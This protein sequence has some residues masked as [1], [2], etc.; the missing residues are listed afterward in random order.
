MKKAIMYGAGNI[1]RGFI[2]QLFSLSG[3]ETVFIDINEAV[4][5]RLNADRSYP[6]YIAKDGS[7]TET[8]VGNVR[9]VNGK[10]ISA[11]AAEIA[12][13]D[14]MATAVG[15]NVLPFVAA[16][17]AA[18]V[19]LRAKTNPVPLNIIICENLLGADAY[20]RE[21][22]NAKL[23]PEAAGF[24]AEKV[25]LVEA[26]IG[27]MV[28]ATPAELAQKNPLIVC[29]EEYCT[30][31]VD[32]AAF[33]GEI[34]EIKNLYPFTPFELFIQRKLFM[35]NM[36][37][38]L[39]AYLGNLHG[40]TY[41]YEAIDLPAI[42]DCAAK[43]LDESAQALAAE[44]KVDLA[45]LREHAADLLHRYTNVLLGDTIARVGKDT[46]RKLAENDRL[47]GALNLCRKHGIKAE[48]IAVGIAAGLRFA[49]EGDAAAAEVSA[50]AREQGVAA[51][52]AKYSNLTD[53]E[54]VRLIEDLYRRLA[55][56][57]SFQL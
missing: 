30:L 31:P 15:V 48:H 9:A 52:L 12:S 16:P 27:R 56:I 33:V 41:I 13:A 23:E 44:H 7:Y 51:A 53:P 26:S 42:R 40:L 32:R 54:T 17:I 8:S 14:I 43:A 36:S 50:C 47:V 28:P 21:L 57:R 18:G 37:H 2:G 49:P 3:Y 46:K 11:V 34:P 19:A 38:A 35:H 22:V 10:D 5:G 29:V 25:G 39:T 1:G 20:L 24:F 55:D 4:V 6:V 45:P